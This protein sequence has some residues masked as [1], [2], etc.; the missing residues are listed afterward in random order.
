MEYSVPGLEVTHQPMRNNPYFSKTQPM[1]D[2]SA[3]DETV[4]P[5]SFASVL[6]YGK[7]GVPF[8]FI[9]ITKEI[10]KFRI[11]IARGKKKEVEDGDK[12]R[13][14]N[15]V[16]YF[17]QRKCLAFEASDTKLYLEKTTKFYYTITAHVA[18]IDQTAKYLLIYYW[19]KFLTLIL[20][21]SGC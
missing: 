13:V 9:T 6:R 17:Y 19:L 12:D 2:L 15:K 3:G 10:K 5:F 14:N 21:I 20:F 8:F 18:Y 1:L 11:S 4:P 16:S 7:C